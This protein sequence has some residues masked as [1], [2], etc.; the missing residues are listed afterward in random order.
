MGTN[1]HN[2]LKLKIMLSEVRLNIFRNLKKPILFMLI[3][4]VQI[5]SLCKQFF[6]C[7]RTKFPVFSLSGKSKNQIPCFPR[8]HPA[9]TFFLYFR[10]KIIDEPLVLS[11]ASCLPQRK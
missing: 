3:I 2:T 7:V 11:G 9:I 4:T 10:R 5:F 6:P 1:V 8:G